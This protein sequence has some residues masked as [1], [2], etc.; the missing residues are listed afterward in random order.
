MATVG[1]TS[2]VT[3]GLLF[4]HITYKLVRWAIRDIKNR[5]EQ[6][7][8]PGRL[9]MKRK[10]IDLN[11][12]LVENHYYRAKGWK[13]GDGS[14]TVSPSAQQEILSAE[15]KKSYGMEATPQAPFWTRLEKPPNPLLLLIFNLILSDIVLSASYASDAVWLSIDGIIAP[16]RTCTAQGWIVSCG[17]L[18]TSGFLFSLSIFSYLGIIRGYKATTRDI[19][20]ACSIVWSLSILLSSLGPMYFHDDTFYGRETTWVSRLISFCSQKTLC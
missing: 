13:P 18:T 4:C 16:S 10:S 12:G 17:C 14:D 2:L 7:E 11:M 6:L 5:K 8:Q 3:S 15:I 20:I 19:I 9:T 1:I